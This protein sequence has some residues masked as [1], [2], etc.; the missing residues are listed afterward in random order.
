MVS[1]SSFKKRAAKSSL[2]DRL[3]QTLAGPPKKKAVR[4]KAPPKP[5]V[6]KPVEP[7][8]SLLAVREKE[9][10]DRAQKAASEL[11]VQAEEAA[12]KIREEADNLRKKVVVQEAELGRKMGVL[13]ERERVIAE[14]RKQVEGKLDEAEKVKKEQVA[15]LEKIALLTKEEAKKIIFKGMEKK[16]ADQISRRIQ[17]AEEEIKL[18]SEEKAKEVLLEAMQRGVTDWVVEYTVSTVQLTDEEIKGRI[19]GREGRN[20]RAFE[21][22]TGVE[23]ELDEA[24]DVYL[25]SFDPVRRE[26]ARRALGKLIKDRR[27]RPSRIEEVVKRTKEEMDKI[28]FEEGERLCR[29]ARVFRLHPD[30]VKLLGRFKFRFSYGQNLAVHTLEVVKIGVAIANQIGAKINVIRLGCLLHDIGKVVIDEEGTHLEL[31]VDL[32]KKYQLPAEVVT[33]VA[34]HH[35]DRP[36]STAESRIVWLADAISGARPGAR[37]EPHEE[38]VKR[39]TEIEE[40]ASSFDGVE[41]AFAYQAGRDVRVLVKPD[42]VSDK[43]LSVLAHK[44]KAELEEKVAYAGQIKLTCIRETRVMETTRSK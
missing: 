21:Q 37:Y 44:I 20:I 12:K 5:S 28:L 2:F 17:E 41:A 33:C 30:L 26:I 23:I 43:E 18:R 19:I 34:E 31:G 13:E 42:K 6:A 40:V 1:F 15:K 10:L 24:N 39:M 7:K 32:L 29:E 36:F 9:I 35:E 25:S 11:R 8:A 3:R 38:Y 27:I 16:L 14:Q 22:A 4:K